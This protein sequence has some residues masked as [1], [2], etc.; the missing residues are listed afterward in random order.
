MRG[1]Y[2]E[3][4][5][6]FV[7]GIFEMYKLR[8]WIA[9]TKEENILDARLKLKS[10]LCVFKRNARL[11]L[12]SNFVA[13]IQYR[14]INAFGWRVREK[15]KWSNRKNGSTKFETCLIKKNPHNKT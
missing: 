13:D 5:V 2:E 10:K 7:D 3:L 8:E 15:N 4:E 12:K 14:E 6:D 1:D 11:K 9:K